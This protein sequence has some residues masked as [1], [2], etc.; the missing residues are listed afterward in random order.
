MDVFAGRAG[1]GGSVPGVREWFGK[2]A[3]TAGRGALRFLG[4]RE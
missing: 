1:R 3:A 2:R 4:F